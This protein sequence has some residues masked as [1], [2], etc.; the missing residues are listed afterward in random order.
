M[1]CEE[2]GGEGP[3]AWRLSGPIFP[4]FKAPVSLCVVSLTP[5]GLVLIVMLVI[6]KFVC[7]LS[8]GYLS[9]VSTEVGL[10]VPSV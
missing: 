3:V 10:R 2:G 9:H 1:V 6:N 7:S 8:K 4:T 5:H